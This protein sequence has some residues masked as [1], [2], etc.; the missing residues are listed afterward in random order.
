MLGD[1]DV[2]DSHSDTWPCDDDD[3]NVDDH[4]DDHHHHEQTNTIWWFSR[5]PLKF[6]RKDVVWQMTEMPRME[7]HYVV[8]TR[9]GR[10]LHGV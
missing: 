7:K 5:F 4:H 3:N 1:V 8:E 2:D 10:P 9:R 6:V